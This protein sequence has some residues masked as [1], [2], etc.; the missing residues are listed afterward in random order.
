MKCPKCG[1]ELDI[2]HVQSPKGGYSFDICI[3]CSNIDCDFKEYN[4]N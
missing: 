2:E 3:C 1:C 4:E